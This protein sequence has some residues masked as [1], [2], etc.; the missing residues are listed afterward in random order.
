MGLFLGL[1]WNGFYSIDQCVYCSVV[2]P[3]VLLLF[4]IVLAIL[5][6]LVF[7]Y[8]VQNWPFKV[9]KKSVLEF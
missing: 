4:W 9:Y 1:E 5:G 6:L 2:Q 3:E 8:E 7:S